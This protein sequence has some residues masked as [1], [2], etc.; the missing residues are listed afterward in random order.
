[1]ETNVFWLKISTIYFSPHQPLKEL[2][3]QR[4]HQVQH[5]YQQHMGLFS[6]W[7]LPTCSLT[8]RPL[9]CSPNAAL[10]VWTAKKCSRHCRPKLTSTASWKPR[11]PPAK[12]RTSLPKLCQSPSIPSIPFLLPSG[13]SQN[14]APVHEKALIKPDECWL[15]WRVADDRLSETQP[16]NQPDLWRWGKPSSPNQH[17]CR[18]ISEWIIGTWV[19]AFFFL[20][21]VVTEWSLIRTCCWKW[22]PT[23]ADFC[24]SG[25][26]RDLSFEA[27]KHSIVW[28]GL[29]MYKVGWTAGFLLR[30]K[31]V[32]LHYVRECSLTACSQSA[33]ATCWWSGG[34]SSRNLKWAVYTHFYVA[35]SPFISSVLLFSF[36]CS[37][38]FSLRE[39]PPIH[40]CHVQIQA[41]LWHHA[42]GS[43]PHRWREGSY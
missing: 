1:M 33:A 15:Q 43:L 19:T 3:R 21:E 14:S 11:R 13:R 28:V 20:S 42:E 6:L 31:R 7:H 2:P 30:M 22:L 27:T 29:I 9:P 26:C 4:K 35:L 38:E 40:P 41:V 24:K 25:V 36:M 34:N 23:G 18:T 10:T 39:D 16:E 8:L 12:V 5:L 37:R 17:I 32:M